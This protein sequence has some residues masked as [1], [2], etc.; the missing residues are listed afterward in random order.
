MATIRSSLPGLAV[1]L[2]LSGCLDAPRL[3]SCAEFPIGTAGCPTACETYCALMVE[4]C[5]S[6][7]PATGAPPCGAASRAAARP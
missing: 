6:V 4:T 3:R 7:L 5:P 2:L 1:A